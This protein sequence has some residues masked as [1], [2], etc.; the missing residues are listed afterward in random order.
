MNIAKHLTTVKQMTVPEAMQWHFSHKAR[1]APLAAQDP[2]LLPRFTDYSNSVTAFFMLT[3][4]CA[5]SL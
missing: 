1:L 4:H 5:S 2:D 3:A